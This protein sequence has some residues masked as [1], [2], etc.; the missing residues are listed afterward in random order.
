M[1]WLGAALCA[2]LVPATAS[3]SELFRIGEIEGVVNFSVGYGI[4]ARVEERDSDL[5]GAGNGGTAPSVNFDDGNLNYDEGIV[6]NQVRGSAELALR[7]RNFGAFVRG[8]GFYDF[9][10]ELGGGRRTDLSHDGSWAVSSGADLQDAYL[11]A[12]F[13]VADVPV[14]LRLGN[15]VINWGESN[16]LRFGIDVIN[17]ID[18]AALAQPTTTARDLFVRQGMIWGKCV[19]NGL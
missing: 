4:L 13:S 11:T 19:K 10:N 18:L 17:P 7:W 5:V 14:Q 2:L 3:A 8:Y 1:K 16:F 12:N 15:Q 9:E 6:S